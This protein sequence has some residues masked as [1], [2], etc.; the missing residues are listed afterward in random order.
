MVFLCSLTYKIIRYTTEPYSC[1]QQISTMR[2]ILYCYSQPGPVT[3]C[4]PIR[5]RYI[6]PNRLQRLATWKFCGLSW[7]QFVFCKTKS[8]GSSFAKATED[9]PGEHRSKAQDA[10]REPQNKKNLTAVTIKGSK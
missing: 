10:P 9:K 2:A 7:M 6:T 1:M 3:S 8:E 4:T 5:L